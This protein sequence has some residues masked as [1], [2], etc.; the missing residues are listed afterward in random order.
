MKI[1]HLAIFFLIISFSTPCFAANRLK[2]KIADG[3]VLTMGAMPDLKAGAGERVVTV[4]F[5]IPKNSL[6]HYTFDG[7]KLVKKPQTS[8][9]K[10]E[11]VQKFKTYD[12]M[13]CLASKIEPE[14]LFNL[15]P[16]AFPLQSFVEHKNWLGVKA[17]VDYLLKKNLANEKDSKAVFDC[18]SAQNVTI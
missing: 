5:D 6:S 17:L 13:G 15:A 3:E 16:Y 11:A 1:K 18:F 9:D 10:E 7:E 2:Y 8:I 4:D 14:S 12:L